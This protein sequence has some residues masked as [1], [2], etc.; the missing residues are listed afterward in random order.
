MHIIQSPLFDFEAFISQKDT[1]RLLKVLETL[2]AEKLLIT[3]EQERWTGRKGYSVRGLWS[4]LIAGLLNQCHTLADVARLLR[5]D[6]ETRLICGFSKD[7]MPGEDD[8][9]PASPNRAFGRTSDN[10]WRRRA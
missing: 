4:A 10:K 5:R 9:V 8:A 6:K 3:L 7:N 1:N 2:P